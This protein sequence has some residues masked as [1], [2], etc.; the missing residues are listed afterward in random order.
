MYAKEDIWNYFIS[1]KKIAVKEI[2]IRLNSI[3][4][5]MQRYRNFLSIYF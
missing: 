1:F 2:Y 3:K 5:P 4:I